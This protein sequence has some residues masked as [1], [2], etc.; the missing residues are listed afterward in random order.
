MQVFKYVF[1]KKVKQGVERQ[2]HKSTWK[3]NNIQDTCWLLTAGFALFSSNIT[4]GRNES[5][6]CFSLC[7]VDICL[8]D[9]I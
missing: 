3:K 4:T 1:F 8:I 9:L 2:R 5:T 6:F 7:F